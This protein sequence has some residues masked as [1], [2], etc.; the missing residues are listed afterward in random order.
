VQLLT[1]ADARYP[2]LLKTIA[3]TPLVL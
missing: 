2:S 1:W 3:D